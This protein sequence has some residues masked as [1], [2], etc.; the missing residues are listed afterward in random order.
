MSL[1][2]VSE[3]KGL[4]AQQIILYNIAKNKYAR[5]KHANNY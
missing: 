2:N 5:A 1:I 4:S 3:Q